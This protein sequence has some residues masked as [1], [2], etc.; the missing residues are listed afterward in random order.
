LIYILSELFPG[1]A[2]ANVRVPLNLT[3]LLDHSGSMSGEKI[4]NM[5]AAVKNIIDQLEPNDVIAIVTF[6]S[7]TRVLVPAQPAYNKEDIKRKVDQ[8][9]DAGGTTMAPAIREAIKQVSQHHSANVT[10]RIVLLTDGEAT[11]KE[12]DSYREADNA[13]GMGIPIIGMGFGTDWKE[14]FI[15]DL[16]DRSLLVG[17]GSHTGDVWYVE[18][19][20][21]AVRIFERMFQNI[22]VMARDVAVNLRLV[23]GIEARRVW[24]VTPLIKDI[25]PGSIQ[26]RAVIIPVGELAKDGAAYLVELTVPPRPAGMVRVAQADVTYDAPG[27]GPQ[28]QAT[29]IIVQFSPDPAL[30]NQFNGRVMNVVEKVQAF[31]L[32]TQALSDAESG[33]VQNATRK[34]RQ[35]VTIL[36]SQ[37][38]NELAQQMQQEANHLEQAGQMSNEGKKTIKLTSRKTV[39]LSDMGDLP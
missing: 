3:L 34:L 28:R 11:D 32:Q 26:G 29:D 17:Q 1:A 23:Q 25:G 35:A 9:K 14:D 5:K 22:Q 13:G 10:S 39:K 30:Y 6:E 24:Q 31:K 7:N 33:N 38:E 8:I 27:G 19:P 21:E 20:D 18:K 16:A 36:L 2:M 15:F 12:T 4:R 37:G